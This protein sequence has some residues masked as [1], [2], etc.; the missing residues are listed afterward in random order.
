MTDEELKIAQVTA[1]LAGK[2]Y[3][4]VPYKGKFCV[5]NAHKGNLLNGPRG[6]GYGVTEARALEGTYNDLWRFQES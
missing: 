3:I 2:K 5:L 6:D 1:R 4:V